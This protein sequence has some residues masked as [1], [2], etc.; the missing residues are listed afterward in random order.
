MDRHSA[1]LNLPNE[2][3]VGVDADHMSVCKFDRAE[4]QKYSPVWRAIKSIV[5]STLADLHACIQ[6]CNLILLLA[7]I[8]T[9]VLVSTSFS[10]KLPSLRTVCFTVPF[11]RDLKF[12]G[13]EDIIT[14]IGQKFEV[15]RRVALA[16]IG[17]VG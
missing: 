6:S 17:G 13:R 12:I 16:G 9:F 5:D 3:A 11:E 4:S 10:P 2:I 1:R 15:Q 8:L 7:C 14:R